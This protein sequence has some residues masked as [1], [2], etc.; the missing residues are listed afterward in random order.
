MC[1]T[2][3]VVRPSV[4]LGCVIRLDLKGGFCEVPIYCFS[5]H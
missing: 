5:I 2:F 4:D 1:E 3:H